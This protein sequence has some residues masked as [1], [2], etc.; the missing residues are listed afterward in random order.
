M[1]SVTRCKMRVSS[2]SNQI[3]AD[4][5]VEY[6]TVELCAVYGDSPENKQ[7]SKWTP[8]AS[9]KIQISNQAAMNK[10]ASGHEFFVDFTPAK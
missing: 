2:V 1:E 5:S 7:W 9:L 4:G 8:S 3:A 6:Q 10:L